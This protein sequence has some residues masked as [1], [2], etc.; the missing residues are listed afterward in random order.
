VGDCNQDGSVTVD[1]LI[2]GVKIALGTTSIDA[3]S[4]FDTNGDGAVTIN[5][6]IAAVN[7]RRPVRRVSKTYWRTG[8]IRGPTRRDADDEDRFESSAPAH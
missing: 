4:S 1:E 3:C 5:E 7:M 2:K 8:M 6:L